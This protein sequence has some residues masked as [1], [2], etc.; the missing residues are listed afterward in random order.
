[1]EEEEGR[2]KSKDKK[3]DKEDRI[4]VEFMEKRNWKIFN[5]CTE[6]NKKGEFT[7]TEG[8]GSTIIDCF[9]K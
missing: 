3:I 4:L 2:R 6:G 1:M 7:F 5:G 9:R 8:R